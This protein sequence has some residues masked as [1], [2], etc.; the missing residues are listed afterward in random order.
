MS[1]D[2]GGH[3]IAEDDASVVLETGGSSGNNGIIVLAE[4]AV[5]PK[6]KA[7][8]VEFR[9]VQEGSTY[10]EFFYSGNAAGSQTEYKNIPDLYLDKIYQD[11]ASLTTYLGPDNGSYVIR[12]FDN[13]YFGFQKS[14]TTWP[15]FLRF[16]DHFRGVL[17]FR[18]KGGNQTWKSLGFTEWDVSGS[19]WGS[20]TAR[21]QGQTDSGSTHDGHKDNKVVP[22][23][24]PPT[25][26]EKYDQT[27]WSHK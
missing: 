7:D 13:P 14:G 4:T 18:I 6:D 20:K 5:K 26:K 15:D 16:S 21:Y 3:Y 11:G 12:G 8:K 25:I 9:V 27:P 19:A 24:T 1:K 22:K 10:A 17:Q 23:D 2:Q